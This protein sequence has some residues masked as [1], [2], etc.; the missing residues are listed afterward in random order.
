MLSS[1]ETVV[2]K[3]REDAMEK[4]LRWMWENL[5]GAYTARHPE[6]HPGAG[7]HCTNSG[8]LIIVCCYINAL[9]KVLLKGGP[10]KKGPKKHQRPDFARFQEF[11]RVCMSDFFNESSAMT[12]PPTPR[13]RSASGDEWLYEVFRCGFVHGY[14]G[15]KVAWGRCARSNRY[16]VKSDGRLTLNI[17]GLVRG[18]Q[19]GLEEFRRLADADA[20]L[21]SRFMEYITKV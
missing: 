5:N 4:R 1:E 8:T 19:R 12:W 21:R 6:G 3:A 10:S 14:P 7:R 16:W 9:G 20:D 17:D 13:G 11:L 18:F 2:T 15:A